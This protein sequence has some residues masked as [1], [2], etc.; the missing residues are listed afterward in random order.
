MHKTERAR[1][2]TCAIMYL[3]VYPCACARAVCVCYECL[4]CYSVFMR[5][6]DREKQR[7]R[8][9]KGE[10]GV[11][12]DLNHPTTAYGFY[13]HNAVGL[14]CDYSDNGGRA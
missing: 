11:E 6:K 9:R 7:K 4:M 10:K 5:M 1:T 3:C 12:G 14:K 8:R 2:S 13:G